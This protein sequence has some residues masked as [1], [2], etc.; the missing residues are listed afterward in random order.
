MRMHK[1][2]LAF[3]NAECQDYVTEK[4]WRTVEEGA[5][6]IILGWQNN[7]DFEVA[8]HSTIQ[9][10]DFGSVRELAEYIKKLDEDDALYE[11]YLWYKDVERGDGTVEEKKAEE[12]LNPKLVEMYG[13][14]LNECGMAER[15]IEIQEEYERSGETARAQYE[16]YCPE[17]AAW[18]KT[19]KLE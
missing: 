16:D 18:K 2:Y 11:E 6:P 8:R 17:P 4:Y 14:R 19:V 15:I 3:E 12:V 7:S 5:V 9:V 1:F 10:T 13:T